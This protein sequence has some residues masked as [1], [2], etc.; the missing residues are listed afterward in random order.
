MQPPDAASTE[1]RSLLGCSSAGICG[2]C[3]PEDP[4]TAAAKQVVC[5]KIADLGLINPVD[6]LSKS[7]ATPVKGKKKHTVVFDQNTARR[8]FDLGLPSLTESYNVVRD[9]RI[10]VL[11]AVVHKQLRQKRGIVSI[12]KAQVPHDVTSDDIMQK[13]SQLLM[14]DHINILAFLEAFEDNN[15]IHLLYEWPEG[16]F[17]VSELSAAVEGIN[18][19]H[20]CKIMFEV[21]SAV[22]AAHTFGVHHMD[23]NLTSILLGQKGQIS[24]VKVFGLGLAGTF[25]PFAIAHGANSPGNKFFFAA[26]D[27]YLE[28]VLELKVIP[29]PKR[30]SMDVWSLGC[31]LFMLCSGRPPFLGDYDQCVKKIIKVNWRFD[32]EFETISADIKDIIEKMLLKKWQLRPSAKDLLAHQWLKSCNTKKSKAAVC[33]EALSKLNIFANKMPHCKQTLSRLIAETGLQ[34][35]QYSDLVQVFKELDLDGNGVIDVE[36]LSQ[37]GVTIEGISQAQIVGILAKVDRNNNSTVDIS[38]FVAAVCMLQE[39]QDEALLK[40]AFNTLDVNGDMRITKAELFHVLRQYSDTLNPQEVSSF[41]S[42]V[43]KDDDQMINYEEFL[44]LFPQ[45]T[46]KNVHQRA[47]H[48]AKKC[49]EENASFHKVKER[50]SRL[51]KALRKMAGKIATLVR[52]F[53]RGSNCQIELQEKLKDIVKQL[54][55]FMG[56]AEKS[57]KSKN[58]NKRTDQRGSTRSSL[59]GLSVLNINAKEE[60]FNLAE[61][62]VTDD[63]MTTQSTTASNSDGGTDA[64]NGGTENPKMRDRRSTLLGMDGARRSSLSHDA[65]R[66]STLDGARRSSLMQDMRRSSQMAVGTDPVEGGERDH[67]ARQASVAEMYVRRLVALNDREEPLTDDL[68][69]LLIKRKRAEV[70][71]MPMEKGV[72]LGDEEEP[73]MGPEIHPWTNSQ[74]EQSKTREAMEYAWG[75]QIHNIAGLPEDEQRQEIKNFEKELFE[76]Y[77]L[78]ADQIDEI[79]SLQK[80]LQYKAIRTWLPP[81]MLWLKEM[82]K[83]THGGSSYDEFH[84]NKL[85]LDGAKYALQMT[86]RILF[87]VTEFMELQGAGFEASFSCEECQ[88]L[89]PK[90]TP[91]LPHRPGDKDSDKVRT[92]KDG[93]DAGELVRAAQLVTHKQ[94]DEDD[95]QPT[96][97]GS[98]TFMTESEKGSK[99]GLKGSMADMGSRDRQS[100]SRSSLRKASMR[101]SSLQ[102]GGDKALNSLTSSAFFAAQGM[103][104]QARASSMIF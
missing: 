23:W 10:G 76:T 70:W 67:H 28:K 53:Q 104:E 98:V 63:I 37:V 49:E 27:L 2:G 61:M 99:I 90:P 101:R 5:A 57:D 52:K 92:P 8:D 47:E 24:P 59:I 74:D 93:E 78:R 1:Q 95:E 45:V 17:L 65:R 85:H 79:N 71:Q 83:L 103:S 18:E 39:S 21:C 3:S 81:L 64:E 50:A 40:K 68:F 44:S 31:I 100:M 6:S 77:R 60:I 54:H 56:R 80:V 75:P 72:T 16:G 73:D 13:I 41:V 15:N 97:I 22:A 12:E 62:S 43:D 69:K 66:S 58:D 88:T 30:H 46:K 26:P 51:V 91:F 102:P 11:Q 32:S 38:E 96:K 86:E 89:M 48:F 25:I 14:V 34:G 35:K 36:E 29:P 33:Q 19:N 94:E 7:R 87:S 82:Q 4:Y 42:A 9:E 20:I 55:D 84:A